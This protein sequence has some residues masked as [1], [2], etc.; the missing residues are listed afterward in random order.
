[1]D[2]CV[3]SRLAAGWRREAILGGRLPVPP[4]DARRRRALSAARHRTVRL[5]AS[6]PVPCGADV[7]DRRDT[8]L[9][10]SSLWQTTAGLSW[11]PPQFQEGKLT[12]SWL[13]GGATVS[14]GGVGGDTSRRRYTLTH[15]DLTGALQLSV[16][17]EYNAAQ[18]SGWYTRLLRDEVLAELRDG[19]LHVHCH[20][21]GRGDWWLAPSP[22]RSFIFRREMPL[23]LDTLRFADREFL[24]LHAAGAPVLVHL[25]D[26]GSETVLSYGALVPAIT[27]AGSG[28]AASTERRSVFNG[29]VGRRLSEAGARPAIGRGATRRD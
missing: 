3:A 2:R 28:A 9:T 21:A 14:A 13:D 10:P 19:A 24:R 1:M 22:L 29:V 25:H 17:A 5:L 12:I 15:N 6:A 26:R 27:A 11:D 18:V 4:S 20:V 23:V 16:G 7:R 8:S